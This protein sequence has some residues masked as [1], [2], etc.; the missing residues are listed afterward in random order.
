MFLFPKNLSPKQEI[1]D[2]VEENEKQEKTDETENNRKPNESSLMDVETCSTSSTSSA[3]MPTIKRH[4]NNKIFMLRMM[5]SIFHLLPLTGICIF[6][7]RYLETQFLMPTN[8]ATFF[9]GTF[10]ILTMGLGISITG[11]IS[12][13]YQLTAKRWSSW[14]VISTL[15]TALGMLALMAIGCD[16]NNYKGL[17][18]TEESMY[19]IWNFNE[20]PLQ[21]ENLIFTFFTDFQ[22]I[23]NFSHFVLHTIP[24]VFVMI[25]C[26]SHCV[27]VMEIF[28]IRLVISAARRRA[29]SINLKFFRIVNA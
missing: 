19:E 8:Q 9:S 22:V 27:A 16:M 5:S 21:S 28:T 20:S 13:K 10:G 25:K 15:L 4:F 24:A 18:T 23:E 12:A 1:S 2:K 17:V 26:M 6:L 3:F 7:P 29:F 11:I 14:V